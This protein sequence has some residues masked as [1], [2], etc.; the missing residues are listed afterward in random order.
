LLFLPVDQGTLEKPAGFEI[1][2]TRRMYAVRH[3]IP[4]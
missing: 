2:L 1:G 4:C 3:A